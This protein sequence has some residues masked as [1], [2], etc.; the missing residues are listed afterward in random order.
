[1]SNRIERYILWLA[2][3]LVIQFLARYF[4]AGPGLEHMSGP[5]MLFLLQPADVVSLAGV[6]ALLP[7]FV[8]AVWIF[9]DADASIAVKVAWF[10]SG[11]LMSYL[12]LIPYIGSLLI[13]Q[14]SGSSDND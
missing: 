12:V 4:G 13:R 6:L 7:T 1:M 9:V 3:A 10:V 11:L 2:P 14:K 5:A 8:T